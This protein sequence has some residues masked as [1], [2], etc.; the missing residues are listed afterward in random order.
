MAAASEMTS[1]SWHASRSAVEKYRKG[2]C[3]CCGRDATH[4]HMQL[5]SATPLH[6]GTDR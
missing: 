2:T 5:P 4:V 3:T 6:T 1:A